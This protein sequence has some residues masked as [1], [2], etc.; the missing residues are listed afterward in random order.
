MENAIANHDFKQSR[1]HSDEERREREEL[2]RVRLNWTEPT[3][4]VTAD[5]VVETAAA[6]ASVPVSA[7]QNMLKVKD[8]KPME[9][10]AREL[11]THLPAG[12]ELWVD[13]LTAT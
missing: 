1:A 4:I 5:D 2:Q 10:A 11:V 9:L 8:V 3:K 7:V 6:R 12:G 13:S